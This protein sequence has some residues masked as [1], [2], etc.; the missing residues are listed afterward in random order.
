MI[1]G[2][3]GVMNSEIALQHVTICGLQLRQYE[4]SLRGVRGQTF[5]LWVFLSSQLRVFPAGG[6]EFL[7]VQTTPL[8]HCLT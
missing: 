7:F 4:A 3:S 5:S 2:V 1:A 6:L 8:G